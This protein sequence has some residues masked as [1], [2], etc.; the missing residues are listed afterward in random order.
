[1]RALQAATIVMGVLIVGGV[2]TI[3]VTIV[4]RLSGGAAGGVAVRTILADEPAGTRIAGASVAADRVALQL[5]GGGPDRVVVI[6]TRN[7]R[8]IAQIG[9]AR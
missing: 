3:L 6:E 7:G 4:S 9:L 1:M 5:Q 8:V 2:A